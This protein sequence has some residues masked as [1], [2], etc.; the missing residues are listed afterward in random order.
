MEDPSNI[1]EFFCIFENFSEVN[2]YT[3]RVKKNS[4]TFSVYITCT[5]QHSLEVIYC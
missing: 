3:T 5:S 1:K 2:L 4:Y